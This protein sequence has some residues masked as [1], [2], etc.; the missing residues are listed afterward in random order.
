[1][2]EAVSAMYGTHGYWCNTRTFPM[3]CKACGSRIFFFQCDH[4]S[5]VLF[6]ELGWPWPIHDCLNDTRP[7]TP[8]RTDEEI[9]EALQGVQFSVRDERRSG[10][11]HGTRRFNGSI[12]DAIVSRIGR[13]ES[14]ARN[15]MR[16]D[17]IGREETLI[18]T[19]THRSQVSLESRFGIARDSI[20]AR[21][22]GG[23]LGGLDTVQITILV[24]EI[25]VDAD[26][27]DLMSYTVWCRPELV[28]EALSEAD[29]VSATI[30]PRDIAG[31][32]VRWVA[33]MVKWLA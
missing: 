29:I 24:D 16:M 25:A 7:S 30:M 26:A 20:G 10:L 31:V 19:V 9:F 13:S 8:E 1:M 33:S 28:P 18:G 11:I 27:L 3:S 4:D 12:D 17:P 21:L 5:R 2:K 15:T 22:V 6:D 23:V 14:S 32:G